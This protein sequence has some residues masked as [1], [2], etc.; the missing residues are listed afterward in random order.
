[1]DKNKKNKKPLRLSSEGRLQLRKNLGPDQVKRPVLGKKSKTIQIVF[2]KK[3]SSKNESGFNKRQSFN[4]PFAGKQHTSKPYDKIQKFS[5]PIGPILTKSDVNKKIDQKKFESN[6]TGLK[7]IK[8][9]LSPVDEKNRKVNIKKILEQEEQEFDKLPSLAKL[10]RAREREKLKSQANENTKISREIIVPEIITVQELANRMAERVADVVKELMKLKIMTTATQT[11]DADTAEIVA[12]E[13]GHR[14]KR[15]S[16]ID[17]LKDIEDI[18]DEENTLELRPP[19]VT[20]MGHVDHGKTSILDAIRDSNVVNKEAGGITQHIGAYQIK[21][22]NNKKI[23][24]ID[25]PGHEA[26]TN[27]RARGSK[28]TDIVVL[29]VAAD[30]GV[31]P[32][33]I[34]AISH[35]KAAKVPIIVAINKIDKPGADANK[36]R[37]ELLSHEI[38]VEKLS[39]DVQDVEVSAL[40][41]INLDK[42]E[43]AILLQ[44][45]ILNL[46]ANPNRKARGVILESRLEKGRGP[47]ASVLIQKGT[48]KVGDVFLSGCEWGKVRA[49]TDDKGNSLDDILPGCPIE[50]LGLNGNPLAGDDFIV[51]DSESVAKEVAKYRLEKLKKSLAI[52]KSN[53]ENMFEKIAAGQISKLPIIIKGDVQGSIDAINFSIEKLSTKEVEADVIYKGVGAITESDVVLAGSSKGFILGFNVRAIPQARDMAKR[54]GIDIRYYSVIYE[55]IDDMKNLMGGLLAPN[56]KEEITGNVEIRKVFKISKIGSVAGCFVKEG[57]I[58]RDSNI[59]LLRDNVVIHS[60]KID[61]LKRFKDEVKDVQQGYECGVTIQEFSDVQ[62][63]DIIETFQIKKELRKL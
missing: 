7:K 43:E 40:K 56:I 45:E 14:V 17:I 12:T 6:K 2:R 30:D 46:K 15:V 47:V 24:F 31:K 37:N 49:L 32:Q 39:G 23:T 29:V 36:V 19:V 57:F 16:E 25:T 35:A 33:T 55:L 34:E 3:T 42:L 11:I 53:V 38:V 28:T 44:S 50:I 27:M 41:K 18:K 9:T 54:E 22:K 48:L 10:K 59:R 13:L 52:N 51:V 20:V 62:D 4:K 5:K 8:K 60:G 21:N 61:S 58:R 26:F 63:G 1:L